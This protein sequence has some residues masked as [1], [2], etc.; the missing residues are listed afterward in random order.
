MQTLVE[1]CTVS[2]G[3]EDKR[4]IEL[5]PGEAEAIARSLGEKICKMVI[6]RFIERARLQQYEIEEDENVMEAPDVAM[7]CAIAQHDVALQVLRSVGGLHAIAQIAGEG[8]ITAVFALQKGCK[9]DPSLLLEADTYASILSLFSSE[10]EHLHWR[11]DETLRFKVETA[12]FEL[13]AHL[14]LTSSKGRAAVAGAHYFK[15]ALN[16]ALEII[17]NVITSDD[18]TDNDK[19]DTG[20]EN[21]NENENEKENENESDDKDEEQE[22][23]ENDEVTDSQDKKEKNGEEV[24]KSV[25]TEPISTIIEDPKLLAASYSFLSA[26]TPVPSARIAL[27]EDGKFIQASSALIIDS[28]DS[29]LQFAALRAIAKLAPYSSSG[30]GSLSADSIG[31]LLQSA[32]ASEPKISENGN[33]G[34]NKNLYHVQAAEGVLVVFDSLPESKQECIF[35]EVIARYTKL[36]KCHSIARATKSNERANGGELA[37]NLTTLMMVARGKDCVAKCFDSDLVSSLVNTVQ[38]RYDP[39]TTIAEDSKDYWDATTTQCLQI[40]AQVFYKEESELLKVGIK[41]RNLKNSVFMVA[42]PGKAPRKAIDFPS[43]LKL[44]SQNGEAAAKIASQR[45]LSYLSNN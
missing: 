37:Y 43:A 4:S 22:G 38:W 8:E 15:C 27:L 11:Q 36:L 32:L 2:N 45:I 42:R 16:R 19:Q 35:R 31:D 25:S 12:G 10:K 24:T 9:E 18:S 1:L 41:V 26:M 44:I 13:L 7:L 5:S 6:K 20:D 40:L 14:C 33:F 29:N 3:K 23:E 30:D 28:S 34:W 21:E 39:K 17:S